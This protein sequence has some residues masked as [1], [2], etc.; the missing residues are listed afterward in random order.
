ME[1]WKIYFCLGCFVSFEK[2][3]EAPRWQMDLRQAT[4]Q[5]PYHPVGLLISTWKASVH[6][7]C[8]FVEGEF[9][10]L[11]AYGSVRQVGVQNKA[12]QLC[13]LGCAVR[14][15]FNSKSARRSPWKGAA[16]VAASQ[17]TASCPESRE[18]RRRAA[19]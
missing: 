7:F 14:R 5:V 15:P 17:L 2:P 3:R 10:C 16:N 8:K 13:T 19:S 11:V 18:A 1:I 9:A 4:Y 12:V 6:D